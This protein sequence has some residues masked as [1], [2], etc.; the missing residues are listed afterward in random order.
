MSYL[1]WFEGK[2]SYI[3]VFMLFMVGG[4]EAV[5]M[6]DSESANILKTLFGAGALA[7]IRHGVS[8][9]ENGTRSGKS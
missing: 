7:S 9:A 6:L 4:A 5:G 2:K 8:K 3:M 1:K